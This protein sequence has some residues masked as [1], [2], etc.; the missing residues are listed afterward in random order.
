M[1]ALLYRL[2]PYCSPRA[3]CV[4]YA[5]FHFRLFFTF[6]VAL[7]HAPTGGIKVPGGIASIVA[8]ISSTR[9]GSGAKKSVQ[10]PS[11][12][13][14]HRVTLADNMWNAPAVREKMGGGDPVWGSLAG[15]LSHFR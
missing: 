5:I 8:K 3:R 2:L 12:A 6:E 4:D 1:L 14:A 10:T 7:N 15:L 9:G 11:R 13:I